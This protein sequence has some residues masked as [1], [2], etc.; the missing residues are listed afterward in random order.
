[1]VT[2]LL[3][4]LAAI[5]VCCI[6]LAIFV[7]MTYNRFVLLRNRVKEAWSDIE[8]LL[9][10]LLLYSLLLMM[11]INDYTHEII[12]NNLVTKFLSKLTKRY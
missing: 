10:T 12:R 11:K 6:I 8:V 3:I 9:K 1:M 7:W 2:V 5:V 4:I